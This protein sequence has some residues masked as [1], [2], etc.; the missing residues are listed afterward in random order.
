MPSPWALW[1]R[2]KDAQWLWCKTCWSQEQAETWL[3]MRKKLEAC[4]KCK[5]FNWQRQ[6]NKMEE[7][8]EE[9]TRKSRSRS[10][11]KGWRK[12][13]Q[14]L[15]KR[16]S[17]TRGRSRSR[18]RGW[19]RDS[20]ASAS[21]TAPGS[22]SPRNRSTKSRSRSRG[23]KK[24][25]Q[26]LDKECAMSTASAS[27]LCSLRSRSR[28]R[29]QNQYCKKASRSSRSSKSNSRGTERKDG[30]AATAATAA[31]AASKKHK[32]QELAK[33][34]PE[35]EA[36]R[37]PAGH[38][39]WPKD[40]SDVE[41]WVAMATE[42][43]D[44]EGGYQKCVAQ[45]GKV[46][47]KKAAAWILQLKKGEQTVAARQICLDIGITQNQMMAL[48]LRQDKIDAGEANKE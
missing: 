37:Q 29:I 27:R 48:A 38:R 31:V 33:G 36:S 12:E 11:G 19:R 41:A 3:F 13:P 35:V 15:A 17:S 10:K 32:P 28:N 14:E 1:K 2:E 25:P 4:R 16:R 44:K 39:S 23:V 22:C 40:A 18:G 9:D 43:V 20:T 42:E 45:I 47:V 30:P 24:E 21:R 8:E 6:S 46:K 26:V 5:E 34:Q 7:S